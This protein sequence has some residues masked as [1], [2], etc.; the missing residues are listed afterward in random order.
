LLP[1]GKLIFR[2]HDRERGLASKLSLAL[3][4]VIFLLNRNHRRPAVLA[5]AEYRRMLEAAGMEVRELPFTNRLPLAH[6]LFTATKP[7]ARQDPQ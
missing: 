7:G 4:R 3:D 1:E 5:A 6:V 2:V